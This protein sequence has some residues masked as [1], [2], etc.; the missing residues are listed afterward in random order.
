V[1]EWANDSKTWFVFGLPVILFFF[2]RSGFPQ[3]VWGRLTGRRRKGA[4]ARSK[5]HRLYRELLAVLAKRGLRKRS[6][7]TPRE[8]AARYRV[9]AG[10]AAIL[11]VT[12]LTD[13]VEVVAYGEAQLPTDKTLELESGLSAFKRN[14][15]KF[16]A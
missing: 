4:S 11:Y 1:R 15:V 5:T 3:W 8:F 2:F 10:E 9:V 7:E 16:V 6:T 14:R 12:L 13:A